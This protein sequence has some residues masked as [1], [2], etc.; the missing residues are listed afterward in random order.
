MSNKQLKTRHRRQNLEEEKK[1]TENEKKTI[2]NRHKNWLL[3]VSY[4]FYIPFI[5]LIP[6]LSPSLFSL[7]SST[8][9]IGY[10]VLVILI[11]NLKYTQFKL[12]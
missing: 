12:R 2:M 7:Y 6:Y 11:Q 8:G 4:I 5:Q 10:T 1:E 3:F 9:W